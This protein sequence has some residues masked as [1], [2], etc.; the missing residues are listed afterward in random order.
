MLKFWTLDGQLISLDEITLEV[1]VQMGSCMD[2]VSMTV[3]NNQLW[4]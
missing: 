2:L 3:T 4:P 1:E